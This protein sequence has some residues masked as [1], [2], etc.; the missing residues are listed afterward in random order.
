MNWF[1]IAP[2][3]LA[4]IASIA[5][6]IAALISLRISK[7][8]A[9]VAELSA[10]AVHHYSASIEYT[11]VVESL[12]EVTQDF[13]GFS[14]NMWVQWARELEAKDN[15]ELGGKDGR[16]LRHVLSNGSEML[17]N[18][19][20]KTRF[21]RGHANQPILSV[22]RH[23]VNNLNDNEYQELLRK[24]DGCYNGFESVFGI[25]SSSAAITTAPAFRWICYQLAKR[26]RTEDWK[27]VWQESWEESGWLYEYQI[28][29]SKIEPVL[30]N[31][32]KT[33]RSEKQKLEH[34]AFPLSH[35]VELFA[36][37]DEILEILESLLED[38]NG[39][40]L[41]TYKD[42]RYSEELSLLVVCSMATANYVAS[43]LSL[44]HRNNY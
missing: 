2:P 37:Y 7:K 33:L 24:A 15:Y 8:A 21:L 43:Q 9:S 12:S 32:Q 1:E 17:A 31:A 6:A 20:I 5:A 28:R 10:L 39:K 3:F 22:I 44:I 35:N 38:C 16:P 40:L 34:T 11:K 36:K 26:V 25:P 14:D 42:W 29:Y 41:E 18:Y 23:G 4:A 19:A 27:G 30:K 13:Y